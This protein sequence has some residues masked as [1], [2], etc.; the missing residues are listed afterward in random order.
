MTFQSE[1]DL[2]EHKH[3]QSKGEY[4]DYFNIEKNR[5]K[6]IQIG[7]WT[8]KLEILF[9]R[10]FLSVELKTGLEIPW[11]LRFDDGSEI[12]NPF[13]NLQFCLNFKLWKFYPRFSMR[14]PQSPI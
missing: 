5:L 13:Q 1:L 6:E 12:A 3:R 7:F 9:E 11:W 8:D 10:S 4:S 14:I 2:S